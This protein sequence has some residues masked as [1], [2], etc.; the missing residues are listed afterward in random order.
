MSSSID[1]SVLYNYIVD[2]SKERKIIPNAKVLVQAGKM[3]SEKSE[4]SEAFLNTDYIELKDGIGDTFVTIVNV[5]E[6]SKLKTDLEELDLEQKQ[7]VKEG[8]AALILELDVL[9]GKVI[10]KIIKENFNVREELNDMIQILHG[11]ARQNNTSLLSCVEIAYNEI[12]DRKGITLE[13][14]T[15]IKDSDPRYKEI[16]DKID[17]KPKSSNYKSSKS[18]TKQKTKKK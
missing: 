14:G 6:L 9:S 7:S 4:I 3:I 13:N 5:F 11:I 1:L 10:D 16:V 12:K 2:W 15:F 8:V 17:D 18:S